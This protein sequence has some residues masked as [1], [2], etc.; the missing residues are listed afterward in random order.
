MEMAKNHGAK[1]QKRLAKQKAKRQA[2]RSVLLKRASKDPTVRLQHAEK[3]PVAQA[4]V[5]DRLW[6]DGIGHALIARRDSEGALIFAVFL[7]DVLC[8]G[9][10][11]AFWRVGSSADIEDMVNKMA[12]FET[13]GLVTSACLAKIVKGAVEFAQSLGF[14]PHPDYR[15]ASMLLEGLDP[16][17][18]PS[19]FTFGRHGRP[20][21][22]QGPHETPAQAAAIMQR[23]Q[24]AGGHFIASLSGDDVDD[25]IERGREIEQF[26]A[27]EDE[28]SADE[29][30]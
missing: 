11:D 21:Y 12:R 2:K 25:S 16:S 27:L 14:P 28:D 23:V 13:M 18:C 8:L 26:E 10:K 1:D 5:G 20:F 17:S 22:I 19:E 3:W 29:S 24:E 4:L 6:A 30:L 9:V 15:H 7:V